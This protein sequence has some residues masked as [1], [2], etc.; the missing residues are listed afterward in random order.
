MTVE[1]LK[2]LRKKTGECW[3]DVIDHRH[4]L[5]ENLAKIGKHSPFAATLR[6]MISDQDVLLDSYSLRIEEC[7][8]EIRRM[9][10]AQP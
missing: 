10:D 8:I 9:E 6:A 3:L 2:N 7:R 1:E 4:L 5:R